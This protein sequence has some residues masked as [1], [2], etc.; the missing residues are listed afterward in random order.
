MRG[1]WDQNEAH[2]EDQIHFE[3]LW[4]QRKVTASDDFDL[5]F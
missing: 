5:F 1:S 4:V 3:L 2:D